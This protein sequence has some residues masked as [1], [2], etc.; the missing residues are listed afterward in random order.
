[1]GSRVESSAVPQSPSPQF[2]EVQKEGGTAEGGREGGQREEGREAFVVWTL[3]SRRRSR[4]GV[5]T[6][7]LP[8]IS[9]P[10]CPPS[11]YLLCPHPVRRSP[12][13]QSRHSQSG[14]AHTVT[15]ANFLKA[16]S[17]PP[18]S[19]G[20]AHGWTDSVSYHCL[21]WNPSRQ[22]LWGSEQRSGEVTVL[23]PGRYRCR[24]SRRTE[25]V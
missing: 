10:C 19:A 9:S 15:E 6:L 7:V 13:G 16:A 21:G 8:H 24:T 4:K 18:V 25:Q 14:Q 23:H 1:M 11:P 2:T 22:G 12:E 20:S 17:A 5:S 3:L